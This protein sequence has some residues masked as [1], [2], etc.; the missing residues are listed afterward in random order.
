[1]WSTEREIAFLT[2][3]VWGEAGR[4]FFSLRGGPVKILANLAGMA[5]CTSGVQNNALR[6]R[7]PR[8]FSRH[9]SQAFLKISP[10][11]AARRENSPRPSPL[12]SKC[13]VFW[14]ELINSYKDRKSPKTTAARPVSGVHVL[15]HFSAGHTVLSPCLSLKCSY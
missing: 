8:F 13:K 6:P 7:H 10:L 14:R 9:I 1:M 12:Q 2:G 5:P 4:A 11:P 3:Q 15:W